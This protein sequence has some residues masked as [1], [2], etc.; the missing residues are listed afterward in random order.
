MQDLTGVGLFGYF[1]A[2]VEVVGRSYVIQQTPGEFCGNVVNVASPLCAPN[3]L[4][5]EF[6]SGI[7]SNTLGIYNVPLPAITTGA[8]YA[9]SQGRVKPGAIYRVD[10]V[11][12]GYSYA[13]RL[14]GGGNFS[15]EVRDSFCSRAL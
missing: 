8:G 2:V 14:I 11:A 1:V 7:S 12:S 6:S 4:D 3:A 10:A 5:V 9:Y 15:F 13:P